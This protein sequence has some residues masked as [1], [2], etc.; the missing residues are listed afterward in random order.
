[1]YSV[2]ICTTLRRV[3]NKYISQHT[4]SNWGHT[5]IYTYSKLVKY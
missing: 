5:K 3:M 1:M 2:Y 4:L